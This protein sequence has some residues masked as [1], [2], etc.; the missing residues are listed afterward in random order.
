VLPPATTVPDT[1]V[2]F[3]MIPPETTWRLP[4]QETSTTTTIVGKPELP[5]A[6]AETGVNAT[7]VGA[8]AAGVIALGALAMR[9]RSIRRKTVFAN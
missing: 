6:L 9:V 2:E 3:P 8:F 1:I 5:P 4:P 7:E